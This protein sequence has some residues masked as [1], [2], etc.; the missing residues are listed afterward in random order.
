M[1]YENFLEHIFIRH[2]SNVK[3]G[4]E[5]MDEILS[6]LENPEKKLEGIHIAGTNGKGSTSSICESLLIS[7]GY[8]TGL[9]TSP[10]L[11]D[12]TE[13]FRLSGVNITHETIMQLYFN[14][15]RIFEDLEASFFEITTA[16]AFKYFYDNKVDAAIMEVGLG[17]RLDA[18]RPFNSTVTVITSISYDH[19]KTLGNSLE[20]IAYEK[21]GIIK[22]NVPV[23]LGDIPTEAK[24]VICKV[25]SDLN[26]SVYIFNKDFF[27]NN[28]EL[29]TDGTCFDYVFP[30]YGV[31]LKGL[32]LNLLGFHQ[33]HNAALALTAVYL[34]TVELSKRNISNHKVRSFFKGISQAHKNINA[35]W[36]GRLQ[37]LSKKP[38]VLIDGAHNEE[39]V[40]TLIKNLKMIFPDYKY[41]FVVAILRDKELDK[42]LQE[43]CSVAESVYISKNS[44]DRAADV[45]EQVDVVLA[46]NKE[47]YGDDDLIGSLQKC[48]ESVNN[49]N[50]MI[51]ITGSLVTIAE[52][53]NCRERI[54][55]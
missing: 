18:T 14:N 20:Q 42:M 31:V 9:N 17:G 22:E 39:G 1:N 19:V 30:K 43:I 29:T 24:E 2:S 41:H 47:C 11:I 15:E 37:V 12:Y 38:F 7:F 46:C 55:M 48:I 16:L 28:V 5:R 40:S 26:A 54:F 27:V 49:D 33:A 23:V 32:K 3:L 10:H 53:L 36:Q 4:L 6:R 34:Y 52:V 25:A 35:N 44:S 50:E 8:V 45:K 13:R 21:A 51:I